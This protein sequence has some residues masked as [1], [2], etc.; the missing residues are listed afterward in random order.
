MDPRMQAMDARIQPTPA[1]HSVSY[2][3][4]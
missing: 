3:G 2:E 4:S 1:F